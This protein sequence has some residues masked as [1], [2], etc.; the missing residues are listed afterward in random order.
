MADPNQV[1]MRCHMV[2]ADR[3]DVFYRMPP[4]GTVA[5][6]RAPHRNTR[7]SSTS[8][9]GELVVDDLGDIDCVGCHMP[10][11]E[12][13]VAPGSA[14]RPVRRH[15]WRGGHDPEMVKGGLTI[16]LSHAAA[17][18]ART[19]E[20]VLTIANTG[21]AHYLPT[22]TPD[23]HLTVELRLLDRDDQVVKEARHTLKRTVMW[24]PFIADLWDTRLP[25]GDVRRYR[26]AYRSAEGAAPFTVEA[27]VRYH[28]LDERRRMRIGYENAEPIAYEV[29]RK[30]L[31][32]VEP[33]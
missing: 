30:R 32:A 28:L 13:A 20:V 31:P 3:W 9:S 11:V 26:F 29:F 1:C 2:T 23:R 5:E 15:L 4:C 16:T 7:P 27:V 21:A 25:H 12:R 19:R 24:R 6:I 22:G 10:L 14:T 33:G 17:T 18:T 8:T